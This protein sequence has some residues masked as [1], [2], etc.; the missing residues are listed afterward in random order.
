[1]IKIFNFYYS[2]LIVIII[3][4]SNIIYIYA[5]DN[6]PQNNINSTLVKIGKINSIV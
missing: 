3:C 2:L 1:M 6:P 5:V 4:L